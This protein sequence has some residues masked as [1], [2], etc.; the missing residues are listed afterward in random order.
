MSSCRFPLSN[1]SSVFNILRVVKNVAEVWAHTRE[2][3][4]NDRG[5]GGMHMPSVSHR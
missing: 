4:V 2:G 3:L 5:L 1:I